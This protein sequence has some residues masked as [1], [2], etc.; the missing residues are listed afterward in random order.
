MAYNLWMTI[1]GAVAKKEP[2]A[3]LPSNPNLVPAE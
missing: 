2:L 3:S 1:K